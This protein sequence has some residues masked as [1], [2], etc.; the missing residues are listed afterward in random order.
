MNSEAAI[1]D[2]SVKAHAAMDFISYDDKD[3]LQKLD[4]LTEAMRDIVD[5]IYQYEQDN[6]NRTKFIEND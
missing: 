1:H 3:E 4:H 2:I 6:P 5:V